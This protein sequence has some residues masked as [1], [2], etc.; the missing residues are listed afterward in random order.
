MSEPTIHQWK[1]WADILFNAKIGGDDP[2]Y[3]SELKA[4]VSGNTI[5]PTMPPQKK[6]LIPNITFEQYQRA[7]ISK[8]SN[9]LGVPNQD[10]AR[11]A[12]IILSMS[13]EECR[14]RDRLAIA[15]AVYPAMIA[16]GY[17]LNEAAKESVIHADELLAE[18]DKPVAAKQEA[19]TFQV[20]DIV[21]RKI[22]RT[23]ELRAPLWRVAE[24][25]EDHMIRIEFVGDATPDLVG[26]CELFLHHRP[27]P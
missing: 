26:A 22:L 11:P 5:L 3:D 21:R 13:A 16:K 17:G 14:N 4:V 1:E 7:N 9:S 10:I 23:G 19:V 27:T 18:L 24:I 8:K 20:G 25:Q 15:K 2:R 12:S 6:I